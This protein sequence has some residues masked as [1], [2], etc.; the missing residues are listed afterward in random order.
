MSARMRGASF[1]SG[2]VSTH[3]G[4]PGVVERQP[5]AD[6]V[7]ERDAQHRL[8]FRQRC[9]GGRLRTCDLLRRAAR[10]AG[11]CGSHEDLQLTQ[12]EPQTAAD[13]GL[14]LIAFIGHP[15]RDYPLL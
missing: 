15:E 2:C 12:R 5:A 11:A 1:R 3:K 13:Q 8:Q 10:A 14:H 6:A 7:E 9:T 4:A